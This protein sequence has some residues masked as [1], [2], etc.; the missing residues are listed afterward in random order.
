MIE[1]NPKNPKQLSYGSDGEIFWDEQCAETRVT[2]GPTGAA[3][4][5]ELGYDPT[6]TMQR[7]AID[8]GRRLSRHK[9]ID[10]PQFIASIARGQFPNDPDKC[11]EAIDRITELVNA[12]EIKVDHYGK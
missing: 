1:D 11:F 2:L 4:L 5:R 8:G 10:D 7:V 9:R 12:G 6:N 3:V